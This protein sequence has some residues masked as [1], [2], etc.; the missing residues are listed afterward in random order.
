MECN[1]D[2]GNNKAD[3]L[4]RDASWEELWTW[5]EPL[6]SEEDRAEQPTG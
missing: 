4:P 5:I 2:I 6:I 3:F 1:W